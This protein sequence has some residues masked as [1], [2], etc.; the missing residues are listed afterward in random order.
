MEMASQA[1]D[2]RVQGGIEID[3]SRYLQATFSFSGWPLAQEVIMIPG[4]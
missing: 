3:A 4:W 1:A 2:T